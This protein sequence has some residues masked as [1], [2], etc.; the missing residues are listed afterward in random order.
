[1]TPEKRNEIIREAIFLVNS[2]TSIGVCSAVFKACP[3]R[4]KG[5][6]INTIPAAFKALDMPFYFMLTSYH[7]SIEDRQSRITFLKAQITC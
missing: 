1:M 4:I 3:S 7:W 2:S 6:P 5:M